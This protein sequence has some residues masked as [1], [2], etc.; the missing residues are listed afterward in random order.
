M[1]LQHIQR[2][3]CTLRCVSIHTDCGHKLKHFAFRIQLSKAMC[4][5][6]NLHIPFHSEPTLPYLDFAAR[7]SCLQLH[8]FTPAQQ[9]RASPA[10]KRNCIKRLGLQT[11]DVCFKTGSATQSKNQGNQR[12]QGLMRHQVQVG[13]TCGPRRFVHEL[14]DSDS[15]KSTGSIA[16]RQQP[17]KHAHAHPARFLQF[18]CCSCYCHG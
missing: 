5:Q 14:S 7:S 9:T 15:L 3:P 11:C 18:F 1:D 2:T 13:M 12:G 10:N 6:T 17:H 16:H 4:A 8:N